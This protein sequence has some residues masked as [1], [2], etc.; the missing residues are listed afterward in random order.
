MK[1]PRRS[2][3]LLAALLMAASLVGAAR[4]GSAGP[5]GGRLMLPGDPRPTPEMG[6]P[7]MPPDPRSLVSC[8]VWLSSVLL[9]RGLQADLTFLVGT[10]RIAPRIRCLRYAPRS[11]SKP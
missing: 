6:G 5:A 10:Q 8:R 11:A 4:E 3:L 2:A 9:V 1:R 7:E